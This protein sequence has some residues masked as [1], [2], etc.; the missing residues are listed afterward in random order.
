MS[1]LLLDPAVL[2]PPVRD[3]HEEWSDFWLRLTNWAADGRVKMGPAT[4][5]L[6]LA[7][8]SE[9]GW[10]EPRFEPR[11]VQP[12]LRRAIATLLQRVLVATSRR[13]IESLEPPYLGEE[14][15]GAALREDIGSCHADVLG[16]ATDVDRW[17]ARSEC[18][19]CDP[20]PPP[21]VA[22]VFEAHRRLAIEA[23]IAVREAMKDRRLRI[24]GGRADAAVLGGLASRFGIRSKS[25]EWLESE[26]HKKPRLDGLRASLRP[27]RDLVFL[28]TGRI[29]HA[30]SLKVERVGHA[31]GVELHRIESAS[32][33]T[34]ALSAM[35]E[36]RVDEP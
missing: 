17:A 32:Q 4:H 11:C 16:V 9:L 24:V 35:F 19:S 12:Q 29:G 28:I 31:A 5:F 7:W 1:N 27:G 10:P 18:A 33:I 2:M 36:H 15:C 14:L 25:V 13:S 26:R 22:L 23:D 8:Y 6:A 21:T 34:S 20:P 3:T 30:A